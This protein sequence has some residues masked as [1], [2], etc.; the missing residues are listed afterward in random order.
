MKIT[1][2]NY[3][4]PLSFFLS[5]VLLLH[6]YTQNKN[7]EGV[8]HYETELKS[9]IE[10]IP[11]NMMKTMIGL[12]DNLTVYVKNGYYRRTSGFT[13]EYYIP[14][15]QKVYLKFRKIDTLYY[16]DYSFDTS[17]VIS[18]T[19]SDEQKTVAGF[20]CKSIT[21]Q[22]SSGTQK[23]FYAPS[24]H[25]DP[26]ADKNNTIGSFNTYTKETESIWLAVNEETTNYKLAHICNRVDQ[27][28]INDNVFNLPNLPLKQFTVQTVTRE[29]EFNRTGG[30]QKYIQ[31]NL[32]SSVGAKYIKIP[33]GEKEAT[34]TVQLSFIISETGEV[35]NIKVLNKG[36]VHSKVADEAIRV[37]KE[38][39]GWKPA[40]RFGEK[41][42][43]MLK[44]P[45]TFSVSKE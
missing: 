34:Q 36:E 44:Q 40:T 6:D 12:G 25:M 1:N 38:S 41:I 23:Y 18:I 43:F 15:D 5:F 19:K 16:V 35:T 24:L 39:Y 26:E 37:V 13:D 20:Q 2:A 27:K 45:I 10:T 31:A 8:L 22:T 14:K 4:F 21:I 33:K 30:W 28:T 29:P 17:R 3:L 7:F 11:D 42:S 32:N 9:K